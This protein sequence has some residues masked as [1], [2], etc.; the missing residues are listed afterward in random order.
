MAAS[1]GITLCKTNHVK[2]VNEKNSECKLH[3][4][5]ACKEFNL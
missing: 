1:V 2:P 4:G 5:T 3:Y